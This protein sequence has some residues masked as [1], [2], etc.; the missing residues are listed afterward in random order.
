[1]NVSA[2]LLRQQYTSSLEATTTDTQKAG[3]VAA[4]ERLLDGEY[5]ATADLAGA[6]NWQQVYL[7]LVRFTE[8]TRVL[9]QQSPAALLPEGVGE[10]DSDL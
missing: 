7:E 6:R 2:F 9:G 10:L 8:E 5:P 4:A 1:M 3:S